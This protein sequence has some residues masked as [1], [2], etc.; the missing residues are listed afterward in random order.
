[1]PKGRISLVIRLA[2]EKKKIE[3]SKFTQPTCREVKEFKRTELGQQL[4]VCLVSTL[5]SQDM[6]SSSKNAHPAC[7]A[8]N[9]TR[10][11]AIPWNHNTGV[12]T[13]S[14]DSSL[15]SKMHFWNFRHTDSSTVGF[16]F[17]DWGDTFSAN[18]F[19]SGTEP[20]KTTQPPKVFGYS[21]TLAMARA[22]VRWKRERELY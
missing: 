14:R 12:C 19:V 5:N 15:R 3:V 7:P 21:S 13:L 11:S 17:L 20:L 6:P 10:P 16:T 1:M 9:S 4:R 2:K 18:D 22:P 8:S